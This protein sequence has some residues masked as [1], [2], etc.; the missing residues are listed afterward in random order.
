MI[1][2][3]M[4]SWNQFL[5]FSPLFSKTKAAEKVLWPGCAAMKLG[6]EL[7]SE[8]YAVLRK[9]IPGLGF[10]SWC[11]AKPT[12]AVGAQSQKE[13]R[14]SQLYNYFEV[15][16][17][18]TVYTMCPNCTRTLS[19]EFDMEVMPV[20]QI[21]ADHAECRRVTAAAFMGA[22]YK[23]HDPCAGREDTASQAAARRILAA[24]QVPYTE[25]SHSRAKTRCCGRRNM[26]FL[27]NPTASKMMLGARLAGAE[28]A[29]IITY[30]ESCVEA[31]R[32]E[33]H[34]SWHLLEVL[35]DRK[36]PRSVKNR[37]LTANKETRNA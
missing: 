7:I 1:A 31:F 10:S 25:F 27:T 14:S 30:C 28:N 33:R 26:L 5:S 16:G 22:E 24:R 18:Q 4:V 15:N 3:A 2:K 35:F 6:A 37:I 21:L 8:T 20:W 34:E 23:L 17:I 13:K 36:A 11:C 9:V 12:F 19:R 32:G 29:G